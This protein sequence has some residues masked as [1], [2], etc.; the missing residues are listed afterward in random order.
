MNKPT[1]I[2]CLV[3]LVIGLTAKPAQ[4]TVIVRQ[5]DPTPEGWSLGLE[6]TYD[7]QSGS[8]DKRDYAAAFNVLRKQGAHEIRAFGRVSYGRVNGVENENQ[9]LVHLRYVR[10]L[11]DSPLRIETFIQTEQDDF[12]NMAERSLVGGVVSRFYNNDEGTRRLLAMV[13]VMREREAHLTD[14]T[15]DRQVTRVTSSLQMS[16]LLPRDNKLYFISYLQPNIDT[17]ESDIRVTAELSL[18]IP[19][20]ERLNLRTGYF[21][22]YNDMPFDD[23]PREKKRLSTGFSYTF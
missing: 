10:G 3:A 11:T 5:I 12:A 17:P 20:S 7:E 4:A 1:G 8:T 14:D 18:A 2:L 19:L 23:I 16:W 22:R 9:G 21:Y 6:G 13:G 15:F